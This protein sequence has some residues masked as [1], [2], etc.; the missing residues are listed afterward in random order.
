M[1]TLCLTFEELSDCF[2]KWLYHFVF[3]PAVYE[4]SDF[5]TSLPELVIISL[6][7]SNHASGCEVVSHCGFD[8]PFPMTNVVEHPFRCLFA[9]CVSF[10]GKKCVFKF[11]THFFKLSYLSFNYWDVRVY[12]LF[13]VYFLHQIY[14]FQI[15]FSTFWIVM[16]HFILSVYCPGR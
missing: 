6:F 4:G 3:P 10:F 11:F 2:P 15:F 16:V 8:L 1:V 12:Y 5:S 13:W 14:D 7:D 9:I